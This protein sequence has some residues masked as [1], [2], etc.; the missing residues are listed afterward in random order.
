MAEK[1]TPKRTLREAIEVETLRPITSDDLISMGD[2]YHKI[3]RAAT[4]ARLEERPCYLCAKCGHSVYAPREPRTGLPYWQHHNGAPEDCPWW[5]GRA[6]SVDEISASQF[7]GAQESPL[8]VRMKSVIETLLEVDRRTEPS[9]IIIDKYL[10]TRNG[11]R[12]PD[13][14]AIYDGAPLVLE[15][16]LSTTQIP[17][18]VQREDFYEREDHR[19]LW[20]TWRFIPPPVTERL[21]SC[22][23]CLWPTVFQVDALKFQGSRSSMRLCG[24]PAAIASR[25]AL[26]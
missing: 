11:R 3:R 14:R 25:V 21:P 24:C 13:V 22:K 17:I 19:L 1:R 10:I 2:E 7:Q 8:H 9:S 6:K 12:R 5:T 16:Q 15:I 23:R 26:M 18:I 4:R 20:L